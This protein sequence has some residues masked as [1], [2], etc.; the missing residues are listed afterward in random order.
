MNTETQ[1]KRP[2]CPQCGDREHVYARPDL[3]WNDERQQ[4]EICAGELS[5]IECTT[6]DA[7]ST[8]DDGPLDLDASGFPDPL[9]SLRIITPDAAKTLAEGLVALIDQFDANA[10]AFNDY[11]DDDRAGFNASIDAAYLALGLERPA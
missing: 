8:L 5:S 11:D 7:G 10:V 4:W 9:D 1:P 6:C 3:R 2:A